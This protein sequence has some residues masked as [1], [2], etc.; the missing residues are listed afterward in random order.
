MSSLG[1]GLVLVLGLPNCSKPTPPPTRQLV[2]L[3]GSP[4]ERGLQHGTQLRSEIR[5]FYTTLLT[6]SLLPFLNREQAG[7]SAV[8]TTYQ[9]PLYQNGQ[10]STQLLLD[11]A[12]EMEHSI[13]AA[14]KQEMQGVADGSGMS[15]DQI[16]LLNTFAEATLAV[17]AVAMAIN[18]SSAPH[19]ESMQ[20]V[21]PGQD[22]NLNADAG[23]DGGS[24]PSYQALPIASAVEL[25]PLTTFRFVLVDP[26][27]VDPSTV[28]VTL[29]GQSFSS[30][31]AALKMVSLPADNNGLRLQVTLVP[32]A[33]LP[34]A[35]IS[36]VTILAANNTVVSDPPPAH[37][38][39]MRTEQISFTTRG[40]G[41]TEEQVPNRGVEDPSEPATS[42]AFAVSGSETVDGQP[43]LAQH[44]ALL[45][46]NTS[47]NHTALFVQHPEGGA[48]FAY[49]GWA[50][51]IWGFS[52]LNSSGQAYACQPSDT[53]NNSAVQNLLN[54]AADLSTA[55]LLVTGTPIGFAGRRI[56]E[57]TSNTSDA[58]NLLR[59]ISF[60]YGW[61]CLLADAAG[62]LRAI[63]TDAA[64]GT[65]ATS[66]VTDFGTDPDEPGNLADGGIPFASI[67]PDDLRT[68]G[69]YVKNLPDMFTLTVQGERVLPQPQWSTSYF[70][71]LRT[72]ADLHDAIAPAIG[73]LDDDRIIDILKRPELVDTMDSMNAV[74]IEPT[75]RIL[76]SAMGTEPATDSPF[77]TFDLS[78]ESP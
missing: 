56:L 3:R 14:Y 50:G 4:Y 58:T 61:N 72:D 41:L 6:A 70:R 47:H 17:R 52:G 74:V 36:S 45:D 18:L 21:Q 24:L 10:F 28:R 53:L 39:F 9:Q 13:P 25:D 71:S 55:K 40:A 19:L 62:S 48:P 66:G 51:I 60:A 26:A 67:G 2:E 7:I 15:Y 11:S 77:E 23:T 1:L 34:Q 30:A 75:T 73:Q 43:R 78:K 54:S 29:N 12:H 22:T 49:V 64:L 65:L 46:A 20:F 5:S 76:R 8:L 35:S 59:S 33:P 16:L 57:E 27:G 44:F 68:T 38:R 37:Q 42:V 63:E 32:P 31:D 69:H